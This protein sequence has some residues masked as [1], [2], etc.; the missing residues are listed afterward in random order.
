MSGGA[1]ITAHRSS[2]TF[3]ALAGDEHPDTSTM[4]AAATPPT[5]TFV[6]FFAGMERP[7]IRIL[8][9]R[10]ILLIPSHLVKAAPSNHPAF[11]NPPRPPANS[12]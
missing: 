9:R 4:A 12:P 2:G 5:T 10:A 3:L 11:A 7:P 6:D 8:N 1:V